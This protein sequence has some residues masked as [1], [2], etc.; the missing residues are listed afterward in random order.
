MACLAKGVRESH[1]E[2]TG[3]GSR[4]ELLWVSTLSLAKA[5]VVR[6][7]AFEHALPDRYL[8]RPAPHIPVPFGATASFG[9]FRAFRAS[10]HDHFQRHPRPTPSTCAGGRQRGRASTMSLIWVADL[11]R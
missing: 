1:R 11:G 4:D 2:T 7:R 9:H 5:R 3:V 8:P 6:I 10:S